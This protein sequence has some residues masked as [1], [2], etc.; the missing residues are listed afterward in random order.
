MNGENG[1]VRRLGYIKGIFRN[2][3]KLPN[4]EMIET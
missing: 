1:V 4:S 2:I 3:L